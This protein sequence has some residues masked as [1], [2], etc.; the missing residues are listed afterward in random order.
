M[1]KRQAAAAALS[2]IGACLLSSAC[3]CG[4]AWAAHP[5]QTEDT[6]T[7]GTGNIEIE[8]G[9]S[10]TR[11]SGATAFVY[12][13]QLSY[14]LTPELD[15]IAQP[16]WVRQPDGHGLGNTNLDFKWRFFGSAPWSLGLRAGAALPGEAR[17]GLPH[18]T[19]SA[20]GLLVATYDEAPLT[21]HTNLGLER[22]PSAAGIRR[23]V[24][25]VS[26]AVMWAA[27]ERLIWT[28]DASATA[29]PD[30]KRKAWPATL[31]AGVIYTI[32][33]GLDADLGYQV[34]ANARPQ[35]RQLLMGLTYRFAP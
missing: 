1:S 29:D 33:P 8:N 12:Q 35:T 7:Q 6:G 31:L 28:V 26:A 23:S 16:S 9:L 21:I 30:P 22:N 27:S 17:F 18:D 14:G 34:S 2:R 25:H 15:L 20:H 19:A 11:A 32:T 13:P 3:L 5:L 4:P 24:G 10:W